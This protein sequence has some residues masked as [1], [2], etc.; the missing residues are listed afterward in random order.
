MAIKNVVHVGAAGSLGEV[1]LQKLLASDFNV[2]MLRR[3]GSKSIPPKGVKVLEADFSSKESLLAALKDVDAVVSTIAN[4]A[5]PSQQIIIDAAIEAG[6]QRFVPSDFGSNLDH[7]AGRSLPVFADKVKIQEYLIEKSKTTSLTWTS[8]ATNVFL[9]WGLEF[10]F[11][12]GARDGKLRLVGTGDDKFSATALDSIGDSVV[13]ILHHPEQTK[14]RTVF[15]DDIKVSQN[16]ILALAKQVA[17]EREW[18]VQH[19]DVDEEVAEAQEKWAKGIINVGTV[20]PFLL[21][22]ALVK[23]NGGYFEKTDNE[24]LGL[25][26]KDEQYIVDVLTRVLK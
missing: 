23:G 5:V 15:I 16:Q 20:I 18:N 17:P 24:L 4:F 3:Q 25:K 14:N 6:V 8:V 13:G 21:K 2:K 26:P 10:G 1:V 22:A 9:D 19:I 11:L 12:L 7:P